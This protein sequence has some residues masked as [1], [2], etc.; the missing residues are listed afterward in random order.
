MGNL[1]TLDRALQWLGQT[2]D[3]QD[4][5]A[6]LISATSQQVETFL[7]YSVLQAAYTR[8]FNG[9]G[10]RLMFVPDVPLVSVQSLIINGQTIP[11]GSA[12]GGTQQSGFYNDD[13]SIGLIGYCFG[14]G[15]QNVTASYTAGRTTVPADLEQ[16]MLEWM[17]ISWSNQSQIGIGSNVKSIASGD[18]KIDFGGEGNVTDVNVVPMPSSVYAVLGIYQRNTGF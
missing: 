9:Q 12:P 14:C 16:A 5:V 7:G 8:T 10:L 6:R 3:P 4:L 2:S 13:V 11:Q 15:F 17:K 1:T 18:V